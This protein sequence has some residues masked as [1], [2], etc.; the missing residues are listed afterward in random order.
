MATQQST[1]DFLLDQLAD[2]GEMRARKMFGEYALYC[3]NKVVGLVCD[4]QLYV[5]ITDQGREYAGK[6]YEEGK[7]YLGAKPSMK[8]DEGRVEDREWLCALIRLTADNLPALKILN[9][10]R[11]NKNQ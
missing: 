8:I 10:K 3:D 5:K 7:A 1:I 4:D 11:I 9:Q 6:Y 2:A